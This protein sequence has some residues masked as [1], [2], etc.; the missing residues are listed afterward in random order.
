MTPLQRE[1]SLL[2][3]T[4]QLLNSLCSPPLCI[5]PLVSPGLVSYGGRTEYQRQER[6][7]ILVAEVLPYMRVLSALNPALRCFYV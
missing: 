3:A 2:R 6:G 5:D 4:A 1:N 7:H